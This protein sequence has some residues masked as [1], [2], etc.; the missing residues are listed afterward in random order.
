MWEMLGGSYGAFFVVIDAPLVTVAVVYTGV[1]AALDVGMS[2]EQSGV[3]NGGVLHDRIIFNILL[4]LLLFGYCSCII[5]CSLNILLSEIF[6]WDKLHGG[7]YMSR[8]KKSA[9]SL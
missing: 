9:L 8:K 4:L 1:G 5:V 7:Q 2:S 3:M 6:L